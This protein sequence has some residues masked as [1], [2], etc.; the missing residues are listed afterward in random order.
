[1][2]KHFLIL[3]LLA[4]LPLAG[5]AADLN[6]LTIR[7]GNITYGS[8]DAPS[9]T[10]KEGNTPVGD[11]TLDAYYTDAACTIHAVGVDDEDADTWVEFTKLPVGKYYVK[12]N[13]TNDF[14]GSS[15]VKSFLVNPAPLTLTITF[16]T[17]FKKY[18]TYDGVTGKIEANVPTGTGFNVEAGVDELK[19]GD[20]I[21]GNNSIFKNQTLKFAYTG[22]NATQDP[23]G[24]DLAGTPDHYAI[25]FSGYTAANYDIEYT[26]DNFDI[27][28]KNIAEASGA[29]ITDVTV[30]LPTKT[31]VYN[32]VQNLP[33]YTV[34]Y[35]SA[36]MTVGED[37][38]V[39][40]YSAST[41]TNSDDV[42]DPTAAGTITDV[43]KYYTE[44]QGKRNFA[45]KKVVTGTAAG[46]QNYIWEITKKSASIIVND[47]LTKK[48]DG[49]LDL[50]AGSIY[51]ISG[52]FAR[53]N[54][55]VT[56]AEIVVDAQG[57]DATD[58][59]V[60]TLKTVSIPATAI[61]GT[62]A[63][64]NLNV[65][66]GTLTVT[67]ADL[68]IT[69]NADQQKNVGEAD[70]ALTF[71]LTGAAA[72]NVPG[73]DPAITEA[74]YIRTLITLTREAGEDPGDYPISVDY[75]ED[76][77]IFDN[78]TVTV[79][80]S[81][82]FKINGGKIIITTLNKSK[83]YGDDD[84]VDFTTPA[85][86]VNFRID[87]IAAADK[88]KFDITKLTMSRE[89][90]ENVKYDAG[91]D[92]YDGY[93]INAAYTG[94][95]IAGYTGFEIVTGKLTITKAPLTITPIVQ[96]IAP[97]ATYAELAALDK[98]AVTA[99]GLKNGDALANL[100][101]N[102][103]IDD[104][105]V[106]DAKASI[107]D[108][109]NNAI[110]VTIA[111]EEKI[112]VSA[113]E[114]VT[115][116]IHNGNYTITY[117]A[118]AD[119]ILSTSGALAT[120]TIKD[121]DTNIDEV[122]AANDGKHLNVK[123]QFNRNQVLGTGSD[124]NRKWEKEKWNSLVLPFDITPLQFCQAFGC[125]AVFNVVDA[126]KTTENNVA[127][128]LKMSGIIKANTP[129]IVKTENAIDGPTYKQF[130]NVTIT[131]PD[132]ESPLVVNVGD[133]GYTFEGTYSKV[134]VDKTKS[135][136]R[137]LL[138][139]SEKWAYIKN[140]SDATWN[141]VPFAAF[142]NLGESQS[143]NAREVTFTM[144]EADG[145]TTTIR[146]IDADTT[147]EGKAFAAQ[148]WYTLDGMKLNAAPTEKGVYINNGKKVVI[149]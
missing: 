110:I 39:L 75:D 23:E 99:T 148:G 138:G 1:M 13:G 65:V 109:Y 47:G 149:K 37:Y 29:G 17:A 146:S 141:I 42:I 36:D 100:E 95:D 26:A 48:Y 124:K 139:N 25:S 10:V 14:A 83:V 88:S 113:D 117:T 15:V 93:T 22:V 91:T 116:S 57:E 16:P 127:F 68:K 87:G 58:A 108:V 123:I 126:D 107:A 55:E 56:D 24:N 35:G 31:A 32:G 63:N 3:M 64:Y 129:F 89:A 128:K 69:V 45:G 140:T 67:P 11:Y 46:Y 27:R 76:D 105:V 21:T 9:L 143:F 136:L 62:K 33:S 50:P 137:F 40:Y 20:Q 82:K 49:T 52:T 77:D 114:T 12:F 79:D 80:D 134:T 2:R 142:V 122:I 111:D 72:T 112:T 118:K 130:N 78:Y 74:N 43:A 71:T 41:R 92:T 98:D 102:L 147:G 18:K 132:T 131:A 84:P 51:Q 125:Y 4:L 54:I 30:I 104:G 103:V 7:V 120:L 5:W 59:S 44:I 101:Y 119:L 85:E 70:P 90:G 96:T 106:T 19:N 60:S 66:P 61:T 115:P 145:S 133:T 135:Y 97:A 53:D 38:E 6:D 86:G 144:Q 28:Q 121:T 81:K 94:A 8:A 34:K 73:S